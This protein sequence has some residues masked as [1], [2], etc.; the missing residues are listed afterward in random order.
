VRPLLEVVPTG[1][2]LPGFLIPEASG[3][4]GEQL[5]AV[6]S[7]PVAQLK[8]EMATC[9]PSRSLPAWP[10]D[11]AAGRPPALE[12]LV[13]A[14]T[15]FHEHVLR[16]MLP[17]LQAELANEVERLARHTVAGGMESTLNSLHP[18]IRW[19]DG[20]L[21]VP[22]PG[23]SEVHLGGRGLV[24]SPSTVWTRPGFSFHW[25][26]RPGL[27]YPSRGAAVPPG[28]RPDQLGDVVG[29]TRA[30]ALA[31]LAAALAAAPIHG[32]STRS[33]ALA[34]GLSEASASTHASMLR[35]AGLVTTH[36]TGRS[37]RHT[38]TDL[39]RDLVSK[40]AS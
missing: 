15:D 5:D 40:S 7:T 23:D 32:H 14:L 36:R 16:P 24:I 13:G 39:G 22:F 31:A 28:A 9:A 29:T 1:G 21:E 20:V 11:L 27:I 37:V 33:L 8:V 12:A 4:F 26:G 35:G 38:L 10:H 17:E 25:H 34:L 19:C 3:G 18:A 6:R 30:K 2:E